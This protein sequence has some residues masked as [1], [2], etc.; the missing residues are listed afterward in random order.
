MLNQFKKTIILLVFFLSVQCFSQ[1]IGSAT[2]S[3]YIKDDSTGKPIEDV[4][5]FISNSIFGAST[6]KNGFYKISKVPAGN[7]D[8]VAS[9]VGYNVKTISIIINKSQKLNIPFKLHPLMYKLPPVEVVANR[10]KEWIRNFKKFRDKLLGK[11]EFTFECK[12]ENPEVL[13]FIIEK[14]NTLI[15]KAIGPLKIVNS[16]LG[17]SI[18]FVLISFIW[19]QNEGKLRYIYRNRFHLIESI[20]EDQLRKWRKNRETAYNGSVRHFLFNLIMDGLDDSGFKVF[21]VN[22]IDQRN[23]LHPEHIWTKPFEYLIKPG[24]FADEHIL[25]FTNYLKIVYTR[26]T[27]ITEDNKKN[28]PQASWLKMKDKEVIIDL[29]GDPQGIMTFEL[30]G[31]WADFGVAEMLPK[32]FIP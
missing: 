15:A 24:Y 21:H 8:L 16:A 18:D 27:A 11:S 1:D 31:Y 13:E 26:E 6:D 14:D 29:Y 10:P 32:Y 4:N 5:V 9:M 22:E 20:D 2:I 12:I 28:K 19:K 17:Y 23:I 3:G 7:H 25:S 30:F